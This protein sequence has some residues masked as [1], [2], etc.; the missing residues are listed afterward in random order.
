MRRKAAAQVTDRANEIMRV[1][2]A[3]DRLVQAI[4]DG[5]PARAVKE[6]L[7]A[8]EARRGELEATASEQERPLP[9][10]HPA[11]A[12]IYRQKVTDLAAALNAPETR[13]E[14]AE[15]LRG[16]IDTIE[17]RPSAEAYDILLRG[18]LA[19]ILTLASNSKKPA[20][21]SRDGL[22]QMALVAGAGFDLCRTSGH[23]RA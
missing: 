10:L 15:I 5:T 17:L 1:S 4:I 6:R 22:S 21:L 14:A 18:D 9:A 20:A 19:G 23:L 8:L 16:L 7:D 11:M 2:A 12:E 13:A 3:I